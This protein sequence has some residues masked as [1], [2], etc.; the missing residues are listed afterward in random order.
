MV[1]RHGCQ[2]RSVGEG[3][4]ARLGLADVAF[5]YRMDKQ[6][7]TV[8]IITNYRK[9]LKIWEYQ[10]NLAGLLRNLYAGQELTVR[11]G[12]LEQ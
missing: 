8:W 12:P 7:L 5:I 9:F 4:S 6:P 1:K 11:T 10:I 2:G 3:L